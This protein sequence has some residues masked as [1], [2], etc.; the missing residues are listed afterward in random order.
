MPAVF[1]CHIFV[2]AQRLYADEEQ[3]DEQGHVLVTGCGDQLIQREIVLSD[4]KPLLGCRQEVGASVAQSLIHRSYANQSMSHCWLLLPDLGDEDVPE[5]LAGMLRKYRR[6]LGPEEIQ[7]AG[8]HVVRGTDG[9][10]IPADNGWCDVLKREE[11]CPR[12]CCLAGRK[13]GIALALATCGGAS[14]ASWFDLVTFNLSCSVTDPMS[15]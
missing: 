9:T 5:L 7:C 15:A 11:I 2:P 1:D 14:L 8:F 13:G 6:Y 3:A 10:R 12:V 4:R